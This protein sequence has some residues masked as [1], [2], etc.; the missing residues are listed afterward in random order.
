MRAWLDEAV[1][2]RE[3]QASRSRLQVNP[4]IVVG[5][6]FTEKQRE[7]FSVKISCLAGKQGTGYIKMWV[8]VTMKFIYMFFLFLFRP[9]FID[10]G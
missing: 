1:K 4:S 3:C 5:V 7:L 10:S 6:F 9:I 2:C 8:N